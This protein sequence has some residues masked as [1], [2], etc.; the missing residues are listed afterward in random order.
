VKNTSP[1]AHVFLWEVN[2]QLMW[3]YSEPYCK[4]TRQGKL[5]TMSHQCRDGNNFC[6]FIFAQSV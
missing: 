5:V 4:C 6:I 1:F 3:H 2:L